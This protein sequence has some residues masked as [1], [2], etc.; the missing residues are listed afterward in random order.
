[1]NENEATRRQFLVGLGAAGAA[2]A[3]GAGILLAPTNGE[4]ASPNL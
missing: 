1:M 4:A 2:A 3:V